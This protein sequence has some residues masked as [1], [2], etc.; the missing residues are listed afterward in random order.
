MEKYSSRI[1]TVQDASPQ[2]LLDW[3]E[4]AEAVW[5]NR[6]YLSNQPIHVVYAYLYVMFGLL[7]SSPLPTHDKAQL[8]ATLGNE[9]LR[10]GKPIEHNKWSANDV[11]QQ[12]E[13]AF[14]TAQGQV[15]GRR[16]LYAVSVCSK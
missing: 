13:V 11:F 4:N 10:R 2:H 1:V 12:A 9:Y 14:R 7:P 8:L 5:A 15:C 6:Q 3:I 16:T